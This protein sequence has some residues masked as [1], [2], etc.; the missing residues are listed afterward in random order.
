MYMT[1][2]SIDFVTGEEGRETAEL[3]AAPNTWDKA[4]WFVT[5]RVLRDE[6]DRK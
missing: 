6:K 5:S 3:T 4:R 2:P 1:D